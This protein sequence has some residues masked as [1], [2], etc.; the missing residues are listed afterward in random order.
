MAFV[1]SPGLR[2][3]SLVRN[4]LS[5]AFILGIF[6]EHYHNRE[7]EGLQHRLIILLTDDESVTKGTDVRPTPVC[8]S[9]AIRV[10]EFLLENKKP[11]GHDSVEDMDY[12]FR[13]AQAMVLDSLVADNTK[14]FPIHSGFTV[15]N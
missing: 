9:S 4:R 5:A 2:S 14:K 6:R 15:D 3:C 8:D 11:T 10:M 1:T 13:T 7:V 12:N